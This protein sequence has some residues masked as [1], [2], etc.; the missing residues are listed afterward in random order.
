MKLKI[1]NKST[2]NMG[3]LEGILTK[4][5]PYAQKRLG[6]D[7]PVQLNLVSDPE[8]AKDPFGKTAYYDPNKMH[9]TLFIDKRHPKDILRSFSH[10]L[11]HHSQNCNG[12]FRDGDETS[13]G[14]AQ[15]NKHLRKLEAMAYLLGNGL[16]VRDYCDTQLKENRNMSTNNTET[17]KELIQK[18]ID[19]LEESK[20]PSLSETVTEEVVEETEEA[21]NEED[22]NEEEVTEEEINEET[23]NEEDVTEEEINEE[24]VTE[25]ESITE[26]EALE[27]EE[28]INESFTNKKDQILYEDLIKKWCK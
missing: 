19:L 9:I 2:Q 26:E 15:K 22:V 28:A 13:E 3:E 20:K 16:I 23:V 24:E 21:I 7:K 14:Y 27:E 25:E 18:A 4:F 11:V 17:I 1:V 12:E 10:E 6:F 5:F 8:N